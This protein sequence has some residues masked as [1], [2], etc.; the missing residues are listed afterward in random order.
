MAKSE[1]IE[2][3]LNFLSVTSYGRKRTGKCCVKC[4]SK[5]ISDEDFR[6]EVSRKEFKIIHWCQSCQDDYYLDPR[7]EEI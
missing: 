5:R 7:H 4:G 6:D 1:G 2:R 3:M